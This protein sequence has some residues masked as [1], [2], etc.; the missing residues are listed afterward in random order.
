MLR[1]PVALDH[2]TLAQNQRSITVAN[3]AAAM[4]AGKAIGPPFIFIII[5]GTC[6]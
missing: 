2:R 3:T 5:D 1:G 4:N 6:C